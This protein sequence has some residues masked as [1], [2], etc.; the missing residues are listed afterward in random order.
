[1]VAACQVF[2][3]NTA[4]TAK[5]NLKELDIKFSHET[6]LTVVIANQGYPDSYTSG[7]VINGIANAN[8][9][10]GVYVFHAGTAIEGELLVASA[11]RVLNVTA[12]GKNISEA[13]DHAYSAVKLIDWPEGYYRSD[14]G[15]KAIDSN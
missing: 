6:A 9:N 3:V 2:E 5:G 1:M 12:L 4:D 11:G 7:S 13:Q 14:I 15:S 10:D 8:K